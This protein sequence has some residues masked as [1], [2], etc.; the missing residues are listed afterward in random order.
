MVLDLKKANPAAA[1][2]QAA[3]LLYSFILLLT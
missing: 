3:E 2:L 1:L